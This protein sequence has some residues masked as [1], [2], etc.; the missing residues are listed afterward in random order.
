MFD[1]A[2]MGNA[3]VDGVAKAVYATIA[4]DVIV[5]LAQDEEDY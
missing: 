4:L 1:E 3:L 2:D 5:D